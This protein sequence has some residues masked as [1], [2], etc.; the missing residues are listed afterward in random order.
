MLLLII[1]MNKPHT[2]SFNTLRNQ[3]YHVLLGAYDVATYSTLVSAIS[4]STSYLQ[5]LYLIV[6]VLSLLGHHSLQQHPF[7]NI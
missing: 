5:E 4:I 3:V 2:N 1:I 6:N 7:Q